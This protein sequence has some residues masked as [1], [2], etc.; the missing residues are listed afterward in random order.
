[1]N[2]WVLFFFKIVYNK[3]ENRKR[4]EDNMEQKDKKEAKKK[5]KKAKVF[6]EKRFELYKAKFNTLEAVVLVGIGGML[7]VLIGEIIFSTASN[8]KNKY[9]NEITKTYNTIIEG[10]YESVDE[11]TLKESAIKGMLSVLKDEH[12]DYLEKEDQEQLNEQLNGTYQG[13]GIQMILNEN[14]IPMI[15][16]V[17]EDSPADKAGVQKGDKILKIN[18]IETKNR[19]LSDVAKLVKK[20]EDIVMTIERDGKEMIK[21]LQI[22]TVEIPSISKEILEDNIGYIKISI[23]A[24][25]T[26]EQFKKA[27]DSFE[28][29]KIEKLI[30]DVRNNSGGHLD[31]AEEILNNF[32][33]DTNV[34]YQ[35]Q[36]KTK[37]K[38]VYGKL[39]AKYSGK[40]A[41]LTNSGSASASEVL[42]AALKENK[43][44]IIVG[45]KTYGKG[46]VQEALTL[47][48]GSMIKY[49]KE[50][51]LTPSGI[52]I[53][54]LGIEP[55]EK[56]EQS[57]E[58]YQ[59][60]S[61]ET[62]KQLKKAIEKLQ[63]E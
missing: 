53:D 49:T 17:Y 20:E 54:K 37:V 5:S 52:S 56:I 9:L 13:L 7:G 46:S 16:N 4:K 51:W 23:F 24:K 38:K 21:K 19:T 58:Y 15:Y 57:K 36:S 11:E 41:V 26:D 22:T 59:N 39:G 27:L 10:S 12:T 14:K 28:N 8:D 55:D 48:D 63:E 47:S 61:S 34:L 45:D 25:N 1:L 32:L 29:A 31:T 40:I 50:M 42:T 35:L 2:P 62:D 3:N 60:P 33:D 6:F 43:K 30:I 18:D 44:A